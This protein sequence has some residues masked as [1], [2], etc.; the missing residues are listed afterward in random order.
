MYETKI[1]VPFQLQVFNPTEVPD[2]TS[3]GV[4]EQFIHLGT[5]SFVRVDAI[6]IN[7]E[8]DVRGYSKEKVCSLQITREAT[9]KHCKFQINLIMQCYLAFTSHYY[10]PAHSAHNLIS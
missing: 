5:E 9:I 3:G 2:V 1:C 7:S 10:Q 6:T 8:P 4:N